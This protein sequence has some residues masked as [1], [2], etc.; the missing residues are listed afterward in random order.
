MTA[1]LVYV[2]QGVREDYEKLDRMGVSVKGA[3]VIARY[4]GA[5][6]GIKPK[7]AAEHGA[8]GCIIY[9]DPKDDGYSRRRVFPKGAFRPEEGV[10]RGGVNDTFYSGDPLTPGYA[11]TKDAKRLPIKDNPDDHQDSRD[12]DLLRRCSATAR[13]DWR[14][15]RAARMARQPADHLPRRARPGEGTSQGDLELGH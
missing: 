12:A 2:N 7:V 11:A 4:G 13:G 5:W 10:Q 8:V 3:I 6:R 15:E 1:P 9:S 14:R